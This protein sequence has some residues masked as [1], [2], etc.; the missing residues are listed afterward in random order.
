[1][2]RVM[3]RMTLPLN[4][5]FLQRVFAP[6]NIAAQ[7]RC[8]IDK[9]ASTWTPRAD[10]AQTPERYLIQLDLAGVDPAAV[11]ISVEAQT[12]IIKGERKLAE[13]EQQWL[14][15]ERSGGA[16]ERRFQLSEQ[17]DVDGIEAQGKFGVLE[18]SLPIR[19]NQQAKK[20]AVQVH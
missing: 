8:E 15:R 11:D 10:I 19:A 12:L 7:T 5:F 9:A 1:M 17:I 16:F 6:Q 4:P 2:E 14:R 13:T 20:I 18:V 3:T